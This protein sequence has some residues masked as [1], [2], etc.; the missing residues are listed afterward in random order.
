MERKKILLCTVPVVELRFA[1][2]KF[3]YSDHPKVRS[4][5]E[6]LVKN[7]AEKGGG[8]C[9]G[10]GRNLDSCDIPGATSSLNSKTT[11]ARK[12]ELFT[13]RLKTRS[14]FSERSR[15]LPIASA[16]RETSA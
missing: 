6:W 13:L 8:S 12:E 7:Q 14:P 11:S 2:V 4:A 9:F 15:T 3:G 10:S 16:R 1:L 5:F